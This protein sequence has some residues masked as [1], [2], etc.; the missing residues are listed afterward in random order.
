VCSLRLNTGLDVCFCHCVMRYMHTNSLCVSLCHSLSLLRSY[1]HTS[2]IIHHSSYIMHH[3]SYI[4]HR[5]SFIIHM[6]TRTH[7]ASVHPMRA[8]FL[9]PKSDPPTLEGNYTK[10]FKD[11]VFKCLQKDPAKV[12]KCVCVCV[13]VCV[14]RSWR[15]CAHNKSSDANVCVCVRV[16]VLCVCVCVCVCECCMCVVVCV[17]C[18]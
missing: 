15:V 6:C 4:I 11:F 7:Q 17:V 16:C 3:T 18:L 12:C 2:Y 9:I 8:L 14:F 1:I 10:H 13:C 5:T